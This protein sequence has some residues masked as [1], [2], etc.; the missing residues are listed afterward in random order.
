[1]NRS[2]AGDFLKSSDILAD[3]REGDSLDKRESRLVT[4]NNMYEVP[5][6]MAHHD[7]GQNL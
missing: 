6:D 1:M 2:T 3:A 4:E 5:S 7:S